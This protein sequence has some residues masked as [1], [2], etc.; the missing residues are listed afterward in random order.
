MYQ[1][2]P[3][4]RFTPEQY[5]ALEEVSNYRSEYIGGEIYAMAG[6]SSD[7]SLIEGNLVTILNQLLE[8]R[9]CRVY[10]SNMRLQIEAVDVF[11]Y[12]DA[13]VVCGQVEFVKGRNDTLKNPLVIFE[14]LSKSTRRYDRGKKFGFYKKISTLEEYVLVDSERAHVEI[15]RRDGN[16]WNAEMS[17]SL[18][19]VLELQSIGLK[20]PVQRL[21]SKVSWFKST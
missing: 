10:T 19:K 8:R 5:L 11:T 16:T 13:M 20:I 1:R 7:H 4:T 2:L 6:G 14:V 18:D 12:P 17:H 21:Y 3:Q 9:P 15:F